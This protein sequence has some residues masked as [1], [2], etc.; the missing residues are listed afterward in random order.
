MNKKERDAAYWRE[1]RL[2][3][4]FGA[5]FFFAVFTILTVMNGSG[6]TCTLIP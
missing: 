5:G 3:F 2:T 1:V 6:Y 4:A